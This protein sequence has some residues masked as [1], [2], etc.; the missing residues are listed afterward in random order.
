MEIIFSTVLIRRQI[1]VNFIRRKCTL[2]LKQMPLVKVRFVTPHFT[3]AI[4][5]N[6]IKARRRGND[7][8]MGNVHLHLK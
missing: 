5:V 8:H 3:V 4:I 1:L 7:K 6:F 2:D